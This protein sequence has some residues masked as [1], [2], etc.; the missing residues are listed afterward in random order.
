MRSSPRATGRAIRPLEPDARSRAATRPYATKGA[1]VVMRAVLCTGGANIA[2]KGKKTPSR[3][4][5]APRAPQTDAP[6]PGHPV[7]PAAGAAPPPHGRP[8]R[9]RLP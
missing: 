7:I 8:V 9:T 1:P 6:G 4:G 5:R 3:N 2:L